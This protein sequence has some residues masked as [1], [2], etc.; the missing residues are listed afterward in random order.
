MGQ[1]NSVAYEE[2]VEAFVRAARDDNWTYVGAIFLCWWR[3]APVCAL[4]DRR[5]ND[6]GLHVPEC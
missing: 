1:L 5:S 4:A 6:T 2:H 3:T